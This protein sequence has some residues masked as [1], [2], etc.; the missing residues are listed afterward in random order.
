[1]ITPRGQNQVCL[2]RGGEGRGSEN[3]DAAADPPRSSGRYLKSDAP[4]EPWLLPSL[5]Y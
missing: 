5:I 2:Q 1:M 3:R 4:V